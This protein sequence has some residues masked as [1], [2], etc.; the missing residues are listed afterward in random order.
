[1]P[2]LD[3]VASAGT[4]EELLT[5]IANLW[6]RTF[7]GDS[8]EGAAVHTLVSW[9]GQM[10]GRALTP[11][12]LAEHFRG[13]AVEPLLAIGK[14]EVIHDKLDEAEVGR[15]FD[16]LHDALRDKRW[17]AELDRL[18]LKMSQNGLSSDEEASY[19]R[20]TQQRQDHQRQQKGPT[21]P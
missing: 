12:M 9:V 13:T 21:T 11:A 17:K 6:C 20:L 10:S 2:P 15:D 8:A 4:R 18:T 1:M 7:D 16:N 5:E 3:A 14:M 19:L